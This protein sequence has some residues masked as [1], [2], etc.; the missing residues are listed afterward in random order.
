MEYLEDPQD[1]DE[2]SL[3]DDVTLDAGENSSNDKDNE[4]VAEGGENSNN[5]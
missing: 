4:S 2:E 3:P 1:F 5:Y